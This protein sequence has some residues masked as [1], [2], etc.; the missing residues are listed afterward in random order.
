MNINQEEF[1]KQMKEQADRRRMK[2]LELKLSGMSEVEI[3]ERSGISRQR[4]NQIIN[5]ARKLKESV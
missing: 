1:N 3:G 5:K 2:F 4:V